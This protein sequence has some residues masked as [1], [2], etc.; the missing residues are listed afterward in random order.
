MWGI[1]K[2]EVHCMYNFCRSKEKLEIKLKEGK[3]TTEKSLITDEQYFSLV[4][5]MVTWEVF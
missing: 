5:L 1:L 3:W 4:I 2:A